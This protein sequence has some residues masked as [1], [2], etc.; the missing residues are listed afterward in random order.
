MGKSAAAVVG[1]APDGGEAG[2]EVGGT[3]RGAT[4]LTFLTSSCFGCREFW[5]GFRAGGRLGELPGGIRVVIVTPG[6]ALEDRRAVGELAPPVVPVVMSA[7]AW[8]DYGVSGSPFAVVLRGG[9]V[10]AEAPL[11]GWED[12]ADLVTRAR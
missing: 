1:V 3:G 8:E 11:S 12:L 10:V 6:A 9:R 4:V 5:E 2:A 7:E